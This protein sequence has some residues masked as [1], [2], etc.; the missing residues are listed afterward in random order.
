MIGTGRGPR[1]DEHEVNEAYLMKNDLDYS[2]IVMVLTQMYSLTKGQGGSSSLL[3][4][5][6]WRLP[7]ES[8][9]SFILA[10]FRV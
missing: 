3:C 4:R 5:A 8:R 9:A 10:S 2:M 1:Y 6:L 7:L